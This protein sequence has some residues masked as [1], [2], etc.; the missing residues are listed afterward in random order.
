MSFKRGTVSARH[1]VSNQWASSP[2]AVVILIIL[3]AFAPESFVN[4]R[5]VQ[6]GCAGEPL[7]SGLTFCLRTRLCILGQVPQN[8]WFSIWTVSVPSLDGVFA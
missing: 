5:V 2:S 8:L 4:S 7:R 6:G 3:E 1:M